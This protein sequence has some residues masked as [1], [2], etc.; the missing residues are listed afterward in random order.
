MSVKRT[1]LRK[2]TATNFAFIR[3]FPGVRSHMQLQR[4]V[5][6]E[7]FETDFASKASSDLI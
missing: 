7:L 3:T 1:R 2:S 6:V 5:I 4:V